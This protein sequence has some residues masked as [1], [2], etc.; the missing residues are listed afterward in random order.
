MLEPL[1]LAATRVSTF[2]LEKPLTNAS[3]FFFARDE[4]L[5]LVT[6]RH[7]VIDEP[8]EHFPSHLQI[9]LH[10]NQENL[11]ESTGFSIPLYEDGKSLWRQGS[12]S[13]VEIDIALVEIERSA[14]P[15]TTAY[16]AF[17]PE[18]LANL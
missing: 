10:T 3:G 1:L 12:D 9:E 14:L 7:V 11:A 2:D 16:L 4:R 6:S 5:F 17:T 13:G 18:H 15:E 8:T